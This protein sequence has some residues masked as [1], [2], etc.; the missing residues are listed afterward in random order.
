MALVLADRVRDTTTTTGTGT[1]TLS[2][3]APTGYQNFSVVG[4]GNTTYYT[5]NA[6]SQWEVG[7]GTYS[8]TGPTLSRDTVLSSSSSGSLVDFAAGTKDVFLTYPSGKSVYQDGSAIKA[9][10]AVLGVPNGGTGATSLTS[11]Y[12]VKGNGTSAVSASVVYDDGTNVGIGTASPTSILD[13]F[14]A[15]AANLNVRGNSATNITAYR[16]S[17]DT[18]GPNLVLRKSRGTSAS[19]TAVAT[20][21][22]MGTLVFSAFGG[23]NN[24]NIATIASNVEYYVSDSLL[25][26]NLTFSTTSTSTTPTEVM[27]IDSS[28]NVGIATASPGAKL[29]IVAQNAIRG[30]GFQPFLTLRDS[31]DSNKGSRI[32][33]AGGATLFSNDSTGG[34]T[35]TERM[36]IDTSGNVGIGTSSPTAGAGYT[37]VSIRNATNGGNIDLGVGSTIY[38]QWLATSASSR[39]LAAN[40]AY[41]TFE[42]GGIERIRID[43]SG[44]VGIGTSSPVARLDIISGSARVYIS[45]QSAT[46]FITAVN[47]TNTA[48]APLAVNGSELI[49]KTGDAERARI[50]SSGNVGI[51]TSS[52][53]VKLDVNGSINFGQTLISGG[54][55]STG[56]VA[57]ELGG[58]RSGSG[59]CYIDLHAT[60]GTD[61]ESRIIRYSGANGGMDIINSGTGGMV[62]SVSGA[63]PIVFQTSG[64][65]RMRISSGG[66]VQVN[67]TSTPTYGSPKLIV[68]G[69]ISGK[70]T[71]T[72]N[73]STATTIAEGAGLL[74]LIRNTTHGGTAVVQYENATTP[75]IIATSGGTTFQTGTPSGSAQI[76]L[77]NKSGNLGVAALASGDRNGAS[78]SVTILQAFT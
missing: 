52:P 78:L 41:Q 38:G 26:S 1:V 34:G 25:S 24:R 22:N 6:G 55:V 13:V 75:I 46:G 62:L 72:I 19:P 47:T 61:F 4:N 69:G 8:S 28:G 10:S 12:L 31:S 51:G 36:R 15:T 30:T 60:N 5:I 18:T 50:D 23:T 29:D 2:G 68:D 7:I 56:D 16:S 35:Y 67:T 70:G 43:T 27:R 20:G 63:A 11:G 14:S 49:L 45:N 32:Q 39:L 65:E 33:T 57:I 17:T 71:V 58:N 73:S 48:Y 74:L 21:D 77:T 59:N 42:V 3:T 40:G 37:S 9:G 64:A 54:G 76:Q 44:N 66:I 53:T